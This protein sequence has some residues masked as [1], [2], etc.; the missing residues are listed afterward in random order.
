MRFD[1]LGVIEAAVFAIRR[2]SGLATTE[3]SGRYRLSIAFMS[4][5]FD[6]PCFVFD[7]LVQD[8]R[9][10]IVGSRILAKGHIAHRTPAS[11]RASFGFQEQGENVYSRTVIRQ[12]RPTTSSLIMKLLQV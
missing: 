7:L 8:A 9:C 10:Q 1:A 4:Q 11:D 5:Q 12:L 6:K 2:L 3:M